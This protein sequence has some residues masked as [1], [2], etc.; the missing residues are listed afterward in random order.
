MLKVTKLVTDSRELNS[1]LTLATIILVAFLGALG[2]GRAR[3][4]PESILYTQMSTVSLRMCATSQKE[5]GRAKLGQWK[6]NR[7]QITPEA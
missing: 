6:Q 4:L 2:L 1:G 5:A 3:M 7:P